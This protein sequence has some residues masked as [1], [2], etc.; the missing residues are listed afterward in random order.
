MAFGESQVQDTYL[1]GQSGGFREP[2]TQTPEFPL[3]LNQAQSLSRP[4]RVERDEAS[5]TE[6]GA[7][8]P[9][10]T[11]SW[12][13]AL[14]PCYRRDGISASCILQSRAKPLETS[15]RDLHMLVLH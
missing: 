2:R 4:G 15:L 12:R 14:T 10:A 1:C 11:V 13:E 5:G 3:Q 9:A 6:E 7:V 8:G